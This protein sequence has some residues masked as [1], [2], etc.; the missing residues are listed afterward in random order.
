MHEIAL[1]SLITA[2]IIFHWIDVLV[3]F[4]TNSSTN[5]FYHRSNKS[6]WIQ[7]FIASHIVYMYPGR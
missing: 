1:E 7:H 4:F 6:V 3:T 5:K 2:L